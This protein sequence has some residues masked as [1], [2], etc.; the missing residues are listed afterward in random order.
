MSLI[1]DLWGIFRVW[2]L[3][4]SF[5]TLRPFSS[6]AQKDSTSLSQAMNIAQLRATTMVPVLLPR[7]K[8][9]WHFSWLRAS[10]M[11]SKATLLYIA[12]FATWTK[13]K[14]KVFLPHSGSPE[15]PWRERIILVRLSNWPEWGRHFTPKACIFED[16]PPCTSCTVSFWLTATE[17]GRKK[18]VCIK[19]AAVGSQ[20]RWEPG[21]VNSI[22][23]SA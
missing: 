3:R 2:T 6:L 11:N 4:L 12:T 1:E 9:C 10:G 14:K 15:S 21:H 18:T 23:V 16:K 17:F 22:A 7:Q 8:G 20:R 5:A 19:P 13:V